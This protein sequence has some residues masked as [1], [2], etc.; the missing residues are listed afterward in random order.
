M[1]LSAW[2]DAA[3]ALLLALALASSLTLSC[4]VAAANASAAV[5]QLKHVETGQLVTASLQ[6]WSD[7]AAV[8]HSIVV[9]EEWFLLRKQ[10]CHRCCRGWK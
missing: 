6:G 4:L 3:S 9:A 5:T 8:T 7:G 2:R 1:S 10:Q